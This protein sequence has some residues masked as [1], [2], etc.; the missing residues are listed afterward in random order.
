MIGCASVTVRLGAEH[1]VA[2][3]P[4]QIY[5]DPFTIRKSGIHADRAGQDLKDFDDT[6]KAGMQRAISKDISDRLVVCFPSPPQ[7]VSGPRPSWVIRGEFTRVEQGSRLLRGAVGFG[8]GATKMECSVRV[9][10]LTEGEPGRRILE[11]KTT[12]GSNAEPGA[13]TSYAT[14]PLSVAIQAV[15]GSGGNLFHGVTEDMNRTAREITA[16]LSDYLYRR[17]LIPKSKWIEPKRDGQLGA[18]NL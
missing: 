3:L 10:D 5:V 1:S 14:D 9:V 11:F 12:G 4:N 8:L 17:K 13:I 6:L 7:G 18:T 16:E 15:V 2:Y